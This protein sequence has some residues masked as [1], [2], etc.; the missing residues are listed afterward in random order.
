MLSLQDKQD[1]ILL[2][3]SAIMKGERCLWFVFSGP[4]ARSSRKSLQSSTL[5]TIYM[6]RKQSLNVEL[7][8]SL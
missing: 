7:A 2:Q 5:L 8:S 1:Q 6:H 4:L 3:K